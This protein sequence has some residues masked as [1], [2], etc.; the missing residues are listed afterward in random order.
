MT[1]YTFN[2]ICTPLV[3]YLNEIPNLKYLKSEC[4]DGLQIVRYDCANKYDTFLNK[5]L[6][7]LFSRDCMMYQDFNIPQHPVTFF[8]NGEFVGMVMPILIGDLE[9]SQSKTNTERE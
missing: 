1:R 3:S 9:H 6:V 5:E 4:I 2:G 8:E 7:E